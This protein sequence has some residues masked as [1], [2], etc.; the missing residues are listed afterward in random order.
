MYVIMDMGTTNTRLYMC[1]NNQVVDHVKGNFGAS[2]GKRNGRLELCKRVGSL[3]N[4]LLE[5]CAVKECDIESIVALG[6]A[7]SEIGLLYIPHI[8]LPAD[9]RTLAENIRKEK[10]HFTCAQIR[11]G[12][13][14][15]RLYGNG[16]SGCDKI[17]RTTMSVS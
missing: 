16:D 4:D 11:A 14:A 7:G 6:M 17:W 8:F 9:A 12:V 5:Q 15:C 3:L 1:A 10:Y 2:F 13:D